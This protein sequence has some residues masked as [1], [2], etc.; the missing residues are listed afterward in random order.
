MERGKLKHTADIEYPVKVADGMGGST[1]TWSSFA[2]RQAAIWGKRGGEHVVNDKLTHA[3]L[4]NI[5]ISYVADLKSGY[6]ITVEDSTFE[7]LSIMPVQFQKRY[8][9]LTCR[10]MD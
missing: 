2:V 9:D 1:E 4:W 10:V 6:R 5:R 8:I 7:I 3:A